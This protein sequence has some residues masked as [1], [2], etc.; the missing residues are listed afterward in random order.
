M[1]LSCIINRNLNGVLKNQRLINLPYI[2]YKSTAVTFKRYLEFITNYLESAVKNQIEFKQNYKLL[3]ATYHNYFNYSETGNLYVGLNHCTTTEFLDSCLM[4]IFVALKAGKAFIDNI[5]HL[6]DKNS[7]EILELKGLIIFKIDH[8]YSEFSQGEF[9]KR[10]FGA[11]LEKNKNKYTQFI[12]F[13]KQ[14]IFS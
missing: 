12:E 11:C 9:E 6:K 3:K 1:T 14:K 13:L 10:M 5:K 4:K 8:F 2:K 7:S